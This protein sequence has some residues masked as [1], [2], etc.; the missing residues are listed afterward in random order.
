MLSVNI[1]IYSYS[2]ISN[3]PLATDS[4]EIFEIYII[5]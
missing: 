1:F 2:Y 4:C 5:L 3:G